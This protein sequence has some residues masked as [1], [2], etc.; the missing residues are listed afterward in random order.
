[1]SVTRPTSQFEMSALKELAESNI[2][3]ISV[4]FDTS[5]VPIGPYGP[6]EQSVDSLRHAST[7]SLSSVRVFGENTDEVVVLVVVAVVV[8]VVVAVVPF[9]EVV[10][11]VVMTPFFAA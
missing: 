11:G 6:L 8:R 3:F 2:E 9:I 10:L 7:A 1:M 5:H 4:T